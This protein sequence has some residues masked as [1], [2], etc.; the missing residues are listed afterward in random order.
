MKAQLAGVH[1]IAPSTRSRSGTRAAGDVSQKR[2]REVQRR[3][4]AQ[5][6]VLPQLMLLPVSDR[7][8]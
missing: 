5:V 1:A 2:Q 7:V 3:R 6:A 8:A 4:E